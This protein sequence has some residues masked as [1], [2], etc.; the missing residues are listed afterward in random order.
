MRYGRA[1]SARKTIQYFQ[2]TV[3]LQTRPY[4]PVLVDGSFVVALHQYKIVPLKQR[5]GRVLQCDG[6]EN[7]K[8]HITQ[9]AVDEIQL[10]LQGLE[11]RK[12]PKAEAFQ[13][14]LK[15]IEKECSVLQT[16]QQDD[17]K[18]D[19]G[20]DNDTTTQ[21]SL[22]P[23]EAIKQHII[24][25][26]DLL[27]ESDSGN[28]DQRR[29][30]YIVAT[31]DEQLLEELRSY[32]TV[33]IMRLANNSVLLLE[34]P[35]KQ[36]Q[37]TSEK[38]EKLK[39]TSALGEKEKKLVDYV[40]QEIKKTTTATAT[41]ARN[42]TAADNNNNMPPH[43]R[44]AK[45]KRAKGPNPLSCKRKRDDDNCTASAVSAS[46]KRRERAA[47]KKKKIGKEQSS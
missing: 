41:T 20:D 29:Q 47:G 9:S 3:N 43:L 12:H 32:G 24:R 45:N 11:K 28:S 21:P 2:R 1:K 37:R 38:K 44:R 8:Y 34:H 42:T 23:R 17:V 33:P 10:L 4:I 25:K 7:I 31:Q 14:S 18:K 5:I 19:N 26:E 36:S 35:S 39:W 40:K 15:W 16:E 13:Q 46:K 30:V 22:S 27:H 6:E